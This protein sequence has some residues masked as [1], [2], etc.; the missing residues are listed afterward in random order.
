MGL[1]EYDIQARNFLIKANATMDIVYICVVQGFPFGDD[2]MYHYKY[3]VVITREGKKYDF[4]FYGSHYDYIRNRRPSK[5]SILASL[6]KYEQPNNVWEFA[7]EYGYEINSEETYNRAN[8]L[9]Q[10]CR[11]QY[12]AL[13]DLFGEELMEELQEIQ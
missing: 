3:Q 4:P 13:L 7:R 8:R 11:D 6:E 12:K 2:K 1:S 10:D 5:Y 9:W